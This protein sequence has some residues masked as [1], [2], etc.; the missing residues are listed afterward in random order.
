MI[1]KYNNEFYPD[2][3]A[4]D[5]LS[6]IETEI[7]NVKAYRPLVYIC[8]PLS[9]NMRANID[10]ARKYCRF[11]VS[12]G[13]IPLAS[14]LLFPQFLNDENP[15]EREMGIHFGNVLMGFC[16]EVWVFGESISQGM[17]K[18]IKRAQ[19]KNYRLR[20]FT[21]ALDEGVEK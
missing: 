11:A 6:F 15:V 17:E 4:G 18:E 7:K 9:G 2:Y 19:Q 12:K 13:F 14:H 3:T 21:D 1:S 5:A 10:K 16:K 20:Y 8:S